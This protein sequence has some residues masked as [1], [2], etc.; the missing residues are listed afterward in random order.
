MIYIAANP[1]RCGYDGSGVHQCH[2]GRDPRYQGARCTRPEITRLVPTGGGL[3]GVQMKASAQSATY[4]EQC[5][6][7][8]FPPAIQNRD[9]K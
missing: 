4:C 3:A 9:F 2:T 8:A 1:C 6:R 5:W 7:E